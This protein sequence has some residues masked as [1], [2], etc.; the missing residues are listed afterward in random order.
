MFCALILFYYVVL[1]GETFRVNFGVWFSCGE[2]SVCWGFLF[3]G[4]SVMMLFVVAVISM[5]VQFYSVMYMLEDASCSRFLSYIS[6]FTFFMLVLVLAD[7]LLVLFVGWEG[8]GL[9]S[10]LLISF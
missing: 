9:C 4:V 7:N 6:L 5:V 10:Y 8:V 2:V 1:C 3:D